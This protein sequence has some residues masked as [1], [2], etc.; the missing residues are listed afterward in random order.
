MG[1]SIWGDGNLGV[2]TEEDR[3]VV[4][5]PAELSME[6]MVL[7]KCSSTKLHPTPNVCF[8]FELMKMSYSHL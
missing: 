6:S 4:C 1:S 5:L 3:G 7:G 8:G 2:M